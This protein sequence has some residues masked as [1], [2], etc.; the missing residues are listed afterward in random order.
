HA[1]GNFWHNVLRG[2]LVMIAVP[3]AIIIL[4]ITVV[5]IPFAVLLLLGYIALMILAGIGSGIVFGSWLAKVLMKKDPAPV[6]WKTVIIGTL[7]LSV[8]RVIPLL[9]WIPAFL[10]FLVTLGA[11]TKHWHENVW[12]NR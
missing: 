5:G 9:G 12:L 6:N 10:F 2:F 4:F 1:L 8:L 3:V 11:I 7:A